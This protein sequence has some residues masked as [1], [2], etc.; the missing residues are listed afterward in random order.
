M[1]ID[2]GSFN[3]ES[4]LQMLMQSEALYVFANLKAM[5]WS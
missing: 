4:V 3:H 1:G 2:L 5:L